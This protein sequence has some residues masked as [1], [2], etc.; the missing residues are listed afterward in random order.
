MEVTI[1]PAA[2][3]PVL[4]ERQYRFPEPEYLAACETFVLRM[5]DKA[6]SQELV[7]IK[8]QCLDADIA[9]KYWRTQYSNRVSG[10]H[11]DNGDWGA[12]ETLVEDFAAVHSTLTAEQ[13]Y[14]QN[15]VRAIAEEL[16]GRQ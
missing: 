16:Q 11:F 13:L 4:P 6:L 2:P 9:L 1:K 14:L 8:R 7:V 10:T 5:Y 3:A 12:A 15:A